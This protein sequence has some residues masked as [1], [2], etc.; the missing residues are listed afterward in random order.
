MLNTKIQLVIATS[1]LL[2]VSFF[3]SA[4]TVWE[5]DQ[6]L[7]FSQQIDTVQLR[8][9]LETLASPAFEGRE[10][11]E[12]GQHLAAD[13]IETWFKRYD[14]LPP[15]EGN[16]QQNFMLSADR[17]VTGNLKINATEFIYG[18]DY[19]CHVPY[20]FKK[21][22]NKLGAFFQL[23]GA[24]LKTFFETTKTAVKNSLVLIHSSN[25]QQTVK[26]FGAVRH[27]FDNCLVVVFTSPEA[28]TAAKR[29]NTRDKLAEENEIVV[30]SN[31]VIFWDETKKEKLLTAIKQ[32]D[33]SFYKKYIA[34]A[35]QKVESVTLFEGKATIQLTLELQETLKPASNVG[36]YIKGNTKSD[37]TL[38]LTAHYDHL[39]KNELTYY[40]GADDDGSGTVALME[41][42]RMFSWATKNGFRPQRN[43]LFLLVSGE[44][45]GLLGSSY[46]VAHPAFPLASTVTDLNI[47]MVGRKDDMHDNINYIYV[48]GSDKLSTTLHKMNEAANERSERFELDY[49]YN[50]PA[51]PNRFYYRSDH[52]NFAQHGIPSIF[53]FSG[54]H[55][56]YHQPGDTAD[57][58]DY[59]KLKRVCRYLFTVAWDVA[60]AP[61]APAVDVLDSK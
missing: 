23:D 3:G 48:I 50:D 60:N 4:Q 2:V 5:Q 43:I 30:A 17:A 41:L 33:K 37:E 10:T 18:Q 24:A 49:T 38:V 61:Q 1:M 29:S 28:I 7:Q 36:G 44:E 51:D 6:W 52:Y 22:V 31:T 55:S 46:Y 25:K 59:E 53:Y 16:Y 11:G 27:Y 19:V 21:D 58:I 54:T 47:D 40:P 12:K 45:K 32:K 35:S 13:F 34:A 26:D 8:T 15:F 42:A 14:L 56:D 20:S 39:G 9:N 57:K